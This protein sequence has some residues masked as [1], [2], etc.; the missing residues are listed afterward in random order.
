MKILLTGGG[1]GGHF[2]PIIAVAEAIH[3]LAKDERLLDADLYYMSDDPYDGELL[4]QND[5]IFKKIY[6]GKMR[7]YFSLLNI[8]DTFKTASGII[9][10]IFSVFNIFP[11]VVFSKGGYASVPALLAARIFKIPVVIHESDSAPGR[12]SRWAGKF[13]ARVAISYAETA[14]YFDKEKVALTGNP[15]R[16]AIIQPATEGAHDFFDFSKE[17]PT[18][19]FIGG[20]LGAELINEMVV[21]VLPELIGH[22]QIIHQTG[23]KNFKTASETAK[24]VLGVGNPK[25][26]NYKPFP[27]LDDLTMK[28]AAGAA[29]VIVSRAGS[30]L[31]EIAAWGKPAIVIPITESNG[32]HQRKNAYNYARKTGAIVIEEGNLSPHILISEIDRIISD[33]KRWS[34]MSSGAKS[35]AV[36]DASYKIA[37]ELIS[38]A[39][40]HE[41]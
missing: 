6:A 21:G 11:D 8:T 30:A 39:L 9:K 38:I 4:F 7:R 35:F 25:S 28:N 37:R 17:L 26:N 19:L 40:S 36:T 41:K 22:C 10:A 2:Y 3:K 13:A 15:I 14:E 12:V 27:Y 1:S 16:E 20:S 33:P 24:V 23:P 34:V 5:I 18:V 29:D 31:F 32:D